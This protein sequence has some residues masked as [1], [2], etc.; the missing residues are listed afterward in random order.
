MN[1]D[2]TNSIQDEIE[3]FQ[4]P[5]AE[6]RHWKIVHPEKS[7]K[8]EM[9][10][11]GVVVENVCRDAKNKLYKWYCLATEECQRANFSLALGKTKSSSNAVKHLKLHGI[12]SERTKS[13]SA[14]KLKRQALIEDLTYS[15][16]YRE[17]VTVA[18]EY[19]YTIMVI[20][21]LLPHCLVESSGF[22]FFARLACTPKVNT[23]MHA[24]DVN[25]RIVE[26]YVSLKN[27]IKDNIRDTCEFAK[28]PMLHLLVDE[29]YCTQL[30]QRYIA[31]RVSYI[32][33]QFEQVSA[34]LSVRHFDRKAIDKGEFSTA[35]E[36][37]KDWVKSVLREFNIDISMIYSATTDAGPDIR[38]MT[39]K[40]LGLEW[41]WCVAHM[42]ANA[43]KEACGMMTGQKAEAHPIREIIKTINKMT[44]RIKNSKHASQAYTNIVSSLLGRKLELKP[45]L[46]IRFIGAVATLERI[47]LLWTCLEKLYSTYFGEQFPLSG[48][49]EIIQ[50]VCAILNRIKLIQEHSQTSSHPVACTTLLLLLEFEAKQLQSESDI[51][52]PNGETIECTNVHLV[53]RQFRQLLSDALN[54]RFFDRYRKWHACDSTRGSGAPA[55]SNLLEMATVMH[56]SYKR[57]SC[58]DGIVKRRTHAE[59][60][61]RISAIQEDVKRSI[62]EKVISL[63]T[64]VA[65]S[66]GPPSKPQRHIRFD[67]ETSDEEDFLADKFV[68]AAIN[69]TD[70]N[71][72]VLGNFEKYMH[73]I[74]KSGRS[75]QSEILLW[76]KDKSH[77]FPYFSEVAR[78]LLGVMASSGTVELDIGIAGM[79]LPRSRLSMSTQN[80]EMKLFIKRNEDLLDWNR[81]KQ[82]AGDNISAH[83]PEAPDFPFVEQEELLESDDLFN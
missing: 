6:R 49:K 52:L 16:L 74:G 80:L 12:E 61:N 37:L 58:L 82:I 44:A 70:I 50:Q 26:L 30:R 34:L 17:D 65:N 55:T 67:Q 15:T 36:L 19:A 1:E 38:C 18:L 5:V 14:S 73:E 72:P 78:C 57:L 35:S 79:Y 39:S 48:K 2:I 24:K 46:E 33:E 60:H 66:K 20:R 27:T 64:R 77:E 43:V 45:Y 62:H 29:W 9:W 8:S 76:W 23:R 47:L 7:S 42:L 3:F 31:I 41:E 71:T 13:M 25:K 63:A 40:L 54:K 59:F 81:I 83:L 51:K 69:D 68:N 56:P 10:T 53:V 32:N 21:S 22:R 75:S 11:N 4:L 28:I